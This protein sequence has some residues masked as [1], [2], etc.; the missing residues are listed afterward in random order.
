[1][2]YTVKLYLSTKTGVIDTNVKVFSDV[3]VE[4]AYRMVEAGMFG[5]MNKRYW[6]FGFGDAEHVHALLPMYRKVEK[7]GL[8]RY[9]PRVAPQRLRGSHQSLFLTLET[10]A[11]SSDAAT[12]LYLRRPG[13]H[14][15][16]RRANTP[17]NVDVDVQD[18]SDDSKEFVRTHEA[19]ETILAL[20]AHLSH[21]RETAGDI[22]QP[23]PEVVMLDDG[24][25]ILVTEWQQVDLPQ[26][27][28]DA[29][30][31]MEQPARESDA[32]TVQGEVKSGDLVLV[33]PRELVWEMIPYGNPF[34]GTPPD[35]SSK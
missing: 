10:L 26:P 16:D 33:E 14:E 20:E 25:A 17:S 29:I 4:L 21:Q 8:V 32:G 28:V 35:A 12:R 6:S 9:L 15:E 24:S 3:C 27:A 7:N 1:M 23:P 19:Q 22:Q 5:T 18:A 2:N 11:E 34:E 31:S 30:G 13:G